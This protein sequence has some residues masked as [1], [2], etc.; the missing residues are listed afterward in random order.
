MHSAKKREPNPASIVEN[1]AE[2]GA[3]YAGPAPRRKRKA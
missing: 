2:F 1:V 3:N